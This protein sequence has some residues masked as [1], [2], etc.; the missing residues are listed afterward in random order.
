[1]R[2]FSFALLGG[3]SIR[4]TCLC[5]SQFYCAIPHGRHGVI[6]SGAGAKGNPRDIALLV[7]SALL[8]FLSSRLPA[9]LPIYASSEAAR[10]PASD[11]ARQ[12]LSD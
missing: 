1:V 2:G 6:I 10:R 7:W 8:L 9:L 11:G 5:K 3:H 4:P 12:N